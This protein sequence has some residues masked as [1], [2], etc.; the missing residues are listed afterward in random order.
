MLNIRILNC[1]KAEIWHPCS[2]HLPN[3]S[4]NHSKNHSD[5]TVFR[6]KHFF[7]D[8]TSSDDPELRYRKRFSEKPIVA[9]TNSTVLILWSRVLALSAW[10]LNKASRKPQP[11]LQISACKAKSSVTELSLL[12]HT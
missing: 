12:S 8:V 2:K 6:P 7:T 11:R 5:M 1:S 10:A 3:H 4:N 9:F